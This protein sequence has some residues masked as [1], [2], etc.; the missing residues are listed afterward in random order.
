VS[1]HIERLRSLRDEIRRHR[2]F[3][4]ILWQRLE[5]GDPVLAAIGERHEAIEELARQFG[6]HV[7][8][9]NAMG[10]VL[11]D[12]DPGL[13]DFPAE[14]KGIPIFLCWRAGE[15]QITFWHSQTEG[16]AGRKPISALGGLQEPRAN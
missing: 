8:A 3:L 16:F 14:V 5:G 11:R 9:V 12:L 1:A 4:D 6:T 2:E 13:V 15:P 7:D 10:V